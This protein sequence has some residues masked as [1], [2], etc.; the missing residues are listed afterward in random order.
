MFASRLGD[1]D[2]AQHPSDFFDPRLACQ[3]PDL[4]VRLPVVLMFGDLQMMFA[5]GRHL[6]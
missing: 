3:W 1:V 5:Q 6:G 4:R 2:P